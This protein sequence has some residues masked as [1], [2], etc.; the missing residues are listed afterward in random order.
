MV[1]STRTMLNAVMAL[2]IVA[3]G[4][5]F[6]VVRPSLAQTQDTINERNR[7]AIESLSR[8]VDGLRN[9]NFDSRLRVLE[10]TVVEVKWLG[11]TAASILLGQ[12][13]L[14]ILANRKPLRGSEP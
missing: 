5:F 14:G 2:W 9:L 6:L 11:R 3:L 1:R 13:L 10:D 4:A 8:E 7:S 12:L